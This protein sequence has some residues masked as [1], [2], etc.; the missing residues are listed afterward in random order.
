MGQAGGIRVVG[1]SDVTLGSGPGA[2]GF[3]AGS[4]E[5]E[6]A[7]L[8]E[9]E[10]VGS[11]GELAGAEMVGDGDAD[12]AVVRLDCLAATSEVYVP[13]GS[14]LGGVLGQDEFGVAEAQGRTVW[15]A[16]DEAVAVSVV[17]V[18]GD[19]VRLA[20]DRLSDLTQA[21]FGVPGEFLPV[22]ADEAFGGV[23]AGVVGVAGLGGSR[24][25][26]L[27]DLVERV[28]LAGAGLGVG[29][30]ALGVLGGVT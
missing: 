27:G 16:F 8:G 23:A 24:G 2:G 29:V 15:A 22:A 17:D 11:D 9:F 7:A 10:G 5:G 6:G 14:G 19:V 4:T 1:S 18:L 3:A 21:P 28:G 30:G 20:L 13:G 26:S 12:L 25:S